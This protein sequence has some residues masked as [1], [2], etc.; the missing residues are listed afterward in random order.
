MSDLIKVA[1]VIPVYN[2]RETTLQGLRSLSKIDKTGLDVRIYIV[3]DGSTDGTADAVRR[4][5]PDVHVIM[6]DGSLHYAGGTNL[7][8]KAAMEW[9]PDFVAPMNDDAIFHDQFLQRMINAAQRTPRSVI[10]GLL[11][12][13]DQ[14]HLVFQVG[15]VWRTWVGGW[16]I[17]REL[18]AFTVPDKPFE[19]ECL[20][21]NCTLIPATAVRECGLMDDAN[22]KHGWGDAQYFMTMRHAG[23]TLLVEPKAYVWCEPNTYPPALFSLPVSQA[24]RHLFVN[25][26]HPMNFKRQFDARWYSAPSKV[27][28]VAAF[29]LFVLRMARMAVGLGDPWKNLKDPETKWRTTQQN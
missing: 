2:R 18:T 15:Q 13:W 17:P 27:Q 14:P 19:V 21:G 24:L 5:F 28:A 23:W 1:I 22:F 29:T 3:D 4:D 11:L 20:V 12:L 26:K 9:N 16:H 25:E 8:I 6:G 10:G 7:G